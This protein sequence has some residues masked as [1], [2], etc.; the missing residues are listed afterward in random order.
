MVCPCKLLE[1]SL[2]SCAEVFQWTSGWLI[3]WVYTTL[4]PPF[5]SLAPGNHLNLKTCVLP[6]RVIVSLLFYF[7]LFSLLFSPLDLLLVVTLP[8]FFSFSDLF[9]HAF[10]L[11]ASVS[12]SFLI[13]FLTF[14]SYTSNELLISVFMLFKISRVHAFLLSAY[15]FLCQPVLNLWT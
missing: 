9:C 10:H 14:F 15:T 5:H 7:P 12:L 3:M 1:F 8:R 4:P 6:F 13:G 2:C 11:V